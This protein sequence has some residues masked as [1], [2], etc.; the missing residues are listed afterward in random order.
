MDSEGG[1]QIDYKKLIKAAFK[2]GTPQSISDAFDIA[3]ELELVDSVRVEGV[4]KRDRGTTVYD[5]ANFALAHDFS[6][7]IRQAANAMVRAGVDADNMLD[8][9][10]KTHLFDAPHFF[11]SFFIYME[12]DRPIESQFYLP[13]RKQ[14]LPLVKAIQGL[15]DGTYDIAGF[16]LPPGIGKSTIAL[17]GLAWTSGRNPFLPNLV[18]SHNTKWVTGAYGELLRFFDPNGEYR[19]SDIFPGLSVISTSAQDKLIGIGYDKSDDMRFKTIQM[20]SISSENSGVFRA[21]NWLYVDDLVGGIEQAL[22]RERMEK[23]WQTYYTDLQQRQQGARKKTLIIGTSWSLLDPINR[24][25]RH[26]ENNPRAKFIVCPVCD[27]DEHSLF[28]YP[29]GLGY[30]D[31]DIKELR[32]VWDE[33]SFNAIYLGRPVEREGLLYEP[34][35]LIYYFDLPEREPDAILALCDT[36]E[37]GADYLFCPVMYQYGTDFYMD[38]VICDNGKVEVLEERVALLLVDRKV[39]MARIESNRGGT[40]FAQNVE[41]KVKELGGMTSITTKW[42]QSNK[43]TRIQTASGMVKAHIRFLDPSSPKYTKEYRQA[44]SFL[45]T[46]SMIG[47]NPHDDVPDGLSMFVDWQMSDRSNVATIMKRPF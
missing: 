43:E 3:R 6:K 19:W 45:T 13:R 33:P 14:L 10:Y 40:I 37:Q 1:E 35:E 26:H 28:N 11:D 15:E 44:M 18:G 31:Q 47:K 34:D 22:S 46:Y 23:L 5:E 21:M 17:G 36:K 12:K 24:L 38:A 32:E 16:I 2:R 9:Y 29:Y 42:T 27:E 25:M 30:T 41:K 7:Q 39:R 4:G 8:L 20:T